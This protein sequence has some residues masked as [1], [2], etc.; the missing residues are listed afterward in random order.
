MSAAT[1]EVTAVRD[2]PVQRPIS[3]R[4]VAVPSRISVKTWPTVARLITRVDGTVE[5]APVVMV[6]IISRL[7]LRCQIPNS[8]C[9]AAKLALG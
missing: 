8:F 1:R 2:M 4:V 9:I 3:P 7:I 6:D 5:I